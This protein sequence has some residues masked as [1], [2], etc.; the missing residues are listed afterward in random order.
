M[1]QYRNSETGQIIDID[2]STAIPE[3]QDLD[4]MASFQNEKKVEDDH[5]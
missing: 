1:A 5:Q 3:E 4:S 2:D